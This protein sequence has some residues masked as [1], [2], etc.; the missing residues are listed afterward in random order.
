MDLSRSKGSLAAFVYGPYS[1][2]VQYARISIPT[3]TLARLFEKVTGDPVHKPDR[4]RSLGRR[5]RHG[6]GLK[7]FILG[8]KSELTEPEQFIKENLQLLRPILDWSEFVRNNG[9][10]REKD[11]TQSSSSGLISARLSLRAMPLNVA[12]PSIPLDEIEDTLHITEFY[13]DDLIVIEATALQKSTVE[14]F[15]AFVKSI[16]DV[17][18]SVNLVREGRQFSSRLSSDLVPVAARAWSRS[19][20]TVETVP[21]FILTYLYGAFT[22]L[23]SSEWRTSI[24]LSAIALE[25]LLAEMYEAEFHEVAPDVPLGSL[26]SQIKD[27][28]R[29]IQKHDPFPKDI[30][31]AIETCNES[32][33]AAVHRG[34]RQLFDKEAYDALLSVARF[35]IWYYFLRTSN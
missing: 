2:A 16:P 25:S 1:N 29:N 18:N 10:L 15:V 32:R 20:P 7:N 19:I 33:I 34:G 28:F 23:D 31:R 21:Q 17:G 4:Y 30:D 13:H 8:L 27:N 35:S 26:H 3:E 24:V 9:A 6:L 14:S 5:A 12:G 22:Y 11:A